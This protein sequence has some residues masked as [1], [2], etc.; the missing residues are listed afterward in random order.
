M[1]LLDEARR[2]GVEY[3]DPLKE[4]A[5]TDEASDVCLH[6]GERLSWHE[7]AYKALA[8]QPTAAT[9]PA[10]IASLQTDGIPFALGS[11]ALPLTHESSHSVV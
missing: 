4:V 10:P 7:Q 6:C 1:L 3:A 11:L 2:L 8:T 9:A 5:F